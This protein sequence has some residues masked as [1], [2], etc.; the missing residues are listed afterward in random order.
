MDPDPDP[1]SSYHQA[2]IGRKPLITT[3]LCLLFDFLSLK[4]DVNVPSRSNRQKLFF[5]ISWRL[6]G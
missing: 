2:K 3:V 6:E 4:N 1:G 5:L